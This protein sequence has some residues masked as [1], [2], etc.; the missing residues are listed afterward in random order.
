[1]RLLKKITN[2][3]KNKILRFPGY[4]YLIEVIDLENQKILHQRTDY[5]GFHS[6]GTFTE[7][8][9][10]IIYLTFDR[11]WYVPPIIKIWDLKH[12]TI[13]DITTSH[14]TQSEC[15]ILEYHNQTKRLILGGFDGSI[16]LYNMRTHDLMWHKEKPQK[17]MLDP[18]ISFSFSGSG[19]KVAV[20]QKDS[21]TVYEVTTGRKHLSSPLLDEYFTC[22]FID[23]DTFIHITHPEK[24]TIKINCKL[25]Y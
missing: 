6:C 25:S 8:E 23:E 14:D 3:E 5:G 16:S 13:T 11:H 17:S 19:K 12:D 7:N 2:L 4:R 10:I 21:F 9:N 15:L 22:Q 24:E 1:M 20:L 18:I